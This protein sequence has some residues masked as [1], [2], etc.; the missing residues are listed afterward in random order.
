MMRASSESQ[1]M[2]Q[3]QTIFEAEPSLFRDRLNRAPF[4]F[5][6]R[7]S[8]H[9]LFETPR[10][11]ALCERMRQSATPKHYAVFQAGRDSPQAK[12]TAVSRDREPAAVM[13]ELA[14]GDGLLRLSMVQQQDDDFRSLHETILGEADALSGFALGREIGWSSMTLL[15]S[16]PGIITPY[17]LDHQSNLLFQIH[18]NKTVWIFDPAD[19]RV[20]PE[21]AIERFYGG[22]AYGADYREEMQAEGVAFELT[23]GSGVHNPPLGPH[24]VRNGA[25]VSLSMSIN[26]SLAACEARA[27]VYQVNRSLRALGLRPTPPGQSRPRDRIKQLPFEILAPGRP[28]NLDDLV[29]R[30]PARL[31]R[32]IAT[33][34]RLWRSRVKGS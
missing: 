16:A 23:P 5:R 12:F 27:R 20:L 19:R 13:A 25:E 6:H 1:A 28:R 17:H 10:L 4:V 21:T 34:R 14:E 9:P 31:L 26:F 7:L 29:R 24:W 32:P 30:G 18:G 15:M 22:D 33:L 8:D 2:P 11:I 3:G